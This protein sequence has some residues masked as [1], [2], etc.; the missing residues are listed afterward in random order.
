MIGIIFLVILLSTLW[1]AVIVL[2][3]PWV[4]AIVPTLAVA[5]ATGG[6][7]AYRRLQARKA[8]Q[9]IERSL[10]AQGDEYAKQVRPDQQPEIEAMQAEFSKAVASLK[11][12]KLAR[13]GIDALSVLPWYLIIGPP[14]V[15]KSTALRNSGLQFPYLSA[16]GGGVR[17]VGGTRNCE[18]W[19]TNEAVIL[20]TAGRYTTEQEDREEWFAFL[21]MLARN[22][23]KRPVNGL[24]VAVSAAELV[25]LDEEGAA[26]LGQRIRE[27]VDEVMARL[28]VI[29]PVYVMF[30]KCDLLAG[31]VEMF[32]DLPKGERGQ[33]WGSTEPVAAKAGS[34]AEVF[35]TRFDELAIV[36]EEKALK[37]LG[38]TR[39]LEDRET[40]FQF[41]A[42]FEGLRA[43][44][45]EFIRTLFAENVYQDTPVM[46]G[47][48][49]SSA[50]QEGR[51]I[52]RMMNAMA[53]AFGV[54]G[55]LP[56][57]SESAVETKS[58]FLQDFF[59]K[60]LFRDQALA[61]LSTKETKRRGVLRYGY[62]AAGFAVAA[63]VLLF[64][65]L[66]FFNNRKLLQSTRGLVDSAKSGTESAENALVK[67][68]PLRERLE[69]LLEG[70]HGLMM[71]FGM[72]QG[73]ALLTSLSGFY[74][75]SVRRALVEPVIDRNMR[76]LQD[77]VAKR[78]STQG[79]LDSKE[80]L[81]YFHKL[82]LYLLLSTPRGRG[83]PLLGESEQAWAANR[84]AQ[85]WKGRPG[86]SPKVA[87][88]ADAHAALYLKLLSRDPSLAIARSESTVAGSRKVLQRLPLI[89][90][91]LEQMI[92][93]LSGE[94]SDLTLV[95]LLDRPLAALKGTGQIRGAFTKKIYREKICDSFPARLKNWD[96][97]VVQSDRAP[98]DPEA[99]AQELRSRYFTQYVTEWRQFLD[100]LT[101]DG[102]SDDTQA[103]VML[104]DL[105]K[106]D[107][108]ALG[109]LF[110]SLAANVRLAEREIDLKD[111]K[112]TLERIGEKVKGAVTGGG[113][114]ACHEEGE[115][116]V[117]AAFERFVSF[118]AAPATSGGSATAKKKELPLDSYQEQLQAV[119][120]ALRAHQDVA[121]RIQT[122]TTHVQSL[123]DEQDAIWRQRFKV[124][125][126]PPLT[127]AKRVDVQKKSGEVSQ[128]WCS[129]VYQFFKKN[130]SN[131]YPFNRKGPDAALADLTDFFKSSGTV[132]SFYDKE[133]KADVVQI[134]DRF[135]YAK[136]LG[137][138][139]SSVY[140][141]DLLNF[142][143]HAQ[144]ARAALFPPNATEAQLA[145]TAH[146]RPPSGSVNVASVTLT[147][148]GQPYS[149]SN[150]PEQFFPM[151]WPVIGKGQG[152]SILVRTSKDSD[153]LERRGEWGFFHLLE[154][155]TIR[156]SVA[157]YFTVS[158]HF[159]KLNAEVFID[160][161]PARNETLFG[162]LKDGQ[163]PQLLQAFRTAG[164]TPPVA[165]GYNAGGC[166]K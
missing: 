124:L 114:S 149:Y 35:S 18:W 77:Y 123:I 64:P 93:E 137:V 59:P 129:E 101:M 95:S 25:E 82:K 120:D 109:Q 62:A 117:D 32:G 14:G 87:R 158:W 45:S 108:P 39:R 74:G 30:N 54:R 72:Y 98:A 31:F 100:L 160:F 150:G 107:P 157:G 11:G 27:R 126:L 138:E 165:A 131:R 94:S 19:L 105:T 152:A 112:G 92:D 113:A 156:P 47:F 151:K 36:I 86:I 121:A 142:L 133:L 81:P 9:E 34:P 146:I 2:S 159:P 38:Q 132:W 85:D 139:A 1:T 43:N 141:H 116:Q 90:P 58:Y 80:A 136:G 22:R 162:V 135:Q 148:D 78:A 61:V 96:A 76:D 50:T 68:D 106:G 33:I 10:K 15:G 69:Y 70:R 56:A 65:T 13:G 29:L 57:P 60:V 75:A 166:T 23:P 40:V 122:A 99:A 44:L 155:G 26:A 145:F 8:A 89:A 115:K 103:L 91:V 130:L 37:R 97:W 164:I 163:P 28:K 143:T 49:F 110:R 21:D 3:L 55:A 63:L 6:I 88:S 128:K 67:L 83:E 84:L 118:G 4:I 66:S 16:R 42:Q 144:Q 147:V 53:S 7:F 24:L 153:L 73:D 79:E 125:L 119:R 51:P 48:Y 5:F 71:G 17:G 12:S 161:K 46:R 140:K 52:D 154:E 104:D 111:A 134:G 102:P 20:D 41:P 127:G